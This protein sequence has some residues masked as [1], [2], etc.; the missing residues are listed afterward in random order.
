[1]SSPKDGRE[2]K[3]LREVDTR[4]LRWISSG[5]LESKLM[6][7]GRIIGILSWSNG[8]GSL[9]TA[10][11]A[12]GRWTL[13]RAGFLRPRITAHEVGSESDYA[14]V[15]MGMGG[16]GALRLSGGQLFQF[17]R[18][19]FWHPELNVL[20]DRSRTV[21]RLKIDRGRPEEE[22][23]V[24]IEEKNASRYAQNISFLAILGWYIVLLTSN[25]DSDG[26]I[27][28]LIGAGAI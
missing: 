11:S 7:D 9:A 14:V 18:S 21:I 2:L 28:A 12:E 10:E 15:L 5:K 16:D 4:A 17:Q 23:S 1:M 22:A 6:A 13:K 27:A 8:T 19:G 20:D 25:Y 26:L 3:S 24:E